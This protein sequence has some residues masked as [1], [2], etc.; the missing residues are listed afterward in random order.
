MAVAWDLLGTEAVPGKRPKRR[1]TA[2]RRS[3]PARAGNR[4]VDG[5]KGPAAPK[6]R[7]D[8]E[9]RRVRNRTV[10]AMAILA[11]V[12]AYVFVWN[13][14]G[15]F[16]GLGSLEAASIEARRGP[17]PPRAERPEQACGGDPV[18]VFEGLDDLLALETTLRG[19]MTLRLALLSLGTPG[20]HID[21]IEAAIRSKV[22]LG[23]LGGS[24]APLRVASDRDGGLH[25]LE[26]ELAEGHVLQACRAADD[27]FE[28]RN[29]QHPHRSDVEVIAV[30]LGSDANLA[31]AVEAAGEK[32]ELATRIAEVLAADVDFLTEA[33][34]HDNVEVMVEKRYLGRRF[35]RYGTVLAV[36]ARGAARRVA[37]YRYKPAGR[38]STFY[39]S[40]GRP[41]TRALL[42]S[43]VQYFSVEN[44]ARGMLPPSVEIIE[45]RLGAV[46][47]LP[48]GTPLVA[49][50]DGTIVAVGETRKEGRF[51][52]LELSDG[53]VARYCH[54]L[55]F[56]GE[57]DE[58]QRVQQGQV[59]G[60]AG[61][62][63]RTPNDRLRLELWV[64]AD[65]KLKTV[66]PLRLTGEGQARPSVEGLPI[67]ESDLERFTED[68]AP[69][70][71]ALK[72]AR[73]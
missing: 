23:L 29:L 16:S 50:G 58:G 39:D 70:R 3:K 65:G 59:L 32:P 7:L 37:H 63:G 55:R 46:Y 45:G 72:A 51:I 62:S 30:E 36:A 56:L 73:R 48:E 54:L 31:S 6:K 9:Q 14:D 41:A 66:D 44:S 68:T 17:L 13:E 40:K 69:Q 19:G 18:R 2:A 34:P 15:L 1:S 49:I 71:R 64:E 21:Q 24:G 8:P 27:S 10:L 52:D 60:L 26:I 22:D 38:A 47:R 33:R 43:P 5:K 25:A 11:L 20:E 35:H 61:H 42:R 67:A 4:R 57:L 12:N 28:V 53:V